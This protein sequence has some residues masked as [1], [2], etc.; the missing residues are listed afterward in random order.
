MYS[1][2][3]HEEFRVEPVT[4]LPAVGEPGTVVWVDVQG[5]GDAKKI[6][7]L[8]EHFGIHRLA[9]EDVV[10]THQRPKLEPY[11]DHYFLVMRMPLDDDAL[12][13]EQL[14]IFLGRGFVLTFQEFPGDCLEPV[15][16]RLRDAKNRIRREGSDYLAYSIM[17][18]VLDAFFP[19]L[20]EISDAL[21]ALESEHFTHPDPATPQRLHTLRRELLTIRRAVSPFREAVNAFIRDTGDDISDYTRLHLRDCHDHTYQILDLV[22]TQREIATGLLDVHLSLVSNRMNEIMKVLTIIATLF[23]PLTFLAGVY[24]M[25]FDPD[26]SPWNMPE[27]RLYFGYPVI[28][29]IMLGVIAA[30]LFAF[31]RLGWLGKPRQ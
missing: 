28:V 27:L 26:T 14:S 13:T 24:G 22:D 2:E 5:L 10:N 12:H 20:D 25:N 3:A 29:I 6:L 19:R 30:E 15:R 8:G 7:A 31:W 1:E 23:I 11:E 16:K 4:A 9:L 17:D 18:A 21:D